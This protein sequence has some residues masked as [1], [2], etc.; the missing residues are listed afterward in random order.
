MPKPKVESSDSEEADLGPRVR[1]AM[2]Q[3]PS[4][5]GEM[6]PPE[7]ESTWSDQELYNYFFSSGFIKP[8]KKTSKPKPTP[9]Q[10]EHYY[11]VLNLRP[12]AKAAAIKK[13]FRQLALR[14]HPDKNHDSSEATTKFQE[15]TEAYEIICRTLKNRISNENEKI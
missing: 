5:S 1:K 14:F 6:P 15:I 13:S 3:F 7:A 8:K 11:S 4:Y 10:M 2:K 9:Q 12:G